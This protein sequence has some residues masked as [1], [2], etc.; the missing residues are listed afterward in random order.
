ML[1]IVENVLFVSGATAAGLVVSAGLALG[2]GCLVFPSGR[3]AGG[4]VVAFVILAM[5]GAVLGTVG[6]LAGAV[7][8]LAEFESRRWAWT[9]WGGVLVG[10]AA[11][12]AVRASSLLEGSL[13]GY[14]IAWMPGTIV[15]AVAASFLGGAAGAAVGQGARWRGNRGSGAGAD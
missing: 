14:A 4:A 11:G 5:G 9:T 13:A 1:R 7:Y 2:F 8:C 15:W 12:I 6:G 3:E 10:L